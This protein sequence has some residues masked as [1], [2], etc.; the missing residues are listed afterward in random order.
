M[1]VLVTAILYHAIEEYLTG[2]RKTIKFDG[3]IREGKYSR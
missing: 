2:R 3:D 1:I